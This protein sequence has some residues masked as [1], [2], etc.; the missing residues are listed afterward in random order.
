[1]AGRVQLESVGVADRYFTD[2]PE[3][4]YWRKVYKKNSRFARE[5]VTLDPHIPGD[6]GKVLKFNIPQNQGDLL[7]NVAFRI[8]LPAIANQNLGTG[9]TKYGW[10]ES[11]G[12]ALVEYVDI[13]VGDIPI[14]RITSDWLTIYSE[15]YFTQTKQTA[16]RQLVGKYAIRSAATPV[17]DDSILYNTLNT[18]YNLTGT[19]KS[20]TAAIHRGANAIQEYLVDIPFFFF[21]SSR[22]RHTRFLNVTG[23]QTCAL[24]ISGTCVAGPMR[25]LASRS[26]PWRATTG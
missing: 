9:Y 5:T 13:F 20:G 21:F 12:H 23:V 3:F 26:G 18:Y 6:F 14:Q 8:K 17:S 7:T 22:R 19:D 16:L 10:I 1:M 25:R 11:V 4:T 24:P 2:D 15:H